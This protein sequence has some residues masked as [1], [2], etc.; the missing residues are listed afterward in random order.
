MLHTVNCNI[1]HISLEE[2]PLVFASHW[3]GVVCHGYYRQKHSKQTDKKIEILPIM[4]GCL[5]G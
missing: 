1:H 2:G 3:S 4:I 5:E